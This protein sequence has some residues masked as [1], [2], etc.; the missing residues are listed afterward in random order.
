MTEAASQLALSEVSGSGDTTEAS[1]RSLKDFSRLLEEADRFARLVE[2]TQ[3]YSDMVPPYIL[4]QVQEDYRK[5]KREVDAKLEAQKDGFR[6]AYEEHLS[7]KEVLEDICKK[8]RD[9]IKELRFRRIV[10]EYE[11]DDV[12]DEVRDLKGQLSESMERID[13]MEEILDQYVIIGFD[14]LMEQ[15][16]AEEEEAAHE[17]EE[18]PEEEEETPLPMLEEDLTDFASEEAEEEEEQSPVYTSARDSAYAPRGY[19]AA[20][21]KAGSSAYPQGYLTILDGTRK[22]DRVPLIPADIMLGSSPNTDV[23]LTDQ[24]ISES[25]ARIFF[26]DRKYHLE[27]LDVL[28]RSYVNGI[29]SKVAEL[30]HND[31]IRLGNLN[32]RVDFTPAG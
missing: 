28:G 14:D 27:N 31:V 32:L 1:L 19:E 7:E 29:Q 16:S 8:L 15:E 3:K 23:M 18:E 26:K 13:Q 4:E 30:N 10:G 9:R 12:R 24:G 20:Q 21:P 11:E 25:H 17:Q 2:K 22:G 5:Q 6:Q